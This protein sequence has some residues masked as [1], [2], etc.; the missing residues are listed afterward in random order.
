M[1]SSLMGTKGRG[2]ERTK[3]SKSTLTIS[4]SLSLRS[5]DAYSIARIR[6]FAR[7]IHGRRRKRWIEE[8]VDVLSVVAI[9]GL[10]AV[11]V[12][13]RLLQVMRKGKH[14]DREREER[15]KRERERVACFGDQESLAME[16]VEG[17]GICTTEEEEEEEEEGYVSCVQIC[18][19]DEAPTRKKTQLILEQKRAGL[20]GLS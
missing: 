18:P 2:G 12:A 17:C 14:R 13:W 10:L 16:A 19:R 4:L 6:E 1:A 11:C 9:G 5:L 8:E 20:I 7:G 3:P 15:E